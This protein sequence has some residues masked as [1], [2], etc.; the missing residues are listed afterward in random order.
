MAYFKTIVRGTMGASE[1]WSTGISWGIFGLSPDVPD[2]AAVDGILSRLITDPSVLTIPP[3]LLQVMGTGA[4]VVGFR[5]E[6]RAEDESTLAVAEGL[7][8]APSAGTATSSKTPQDAVVISLRTATPGARGRGRLYWPALGAALNGS[9]QL[10]TPTPAA[11][12]AGAATWLNAIG[13]QI[14]DY[15]TDIGA[16]KSAVLVVRSVT[17]HTNADVNQLQVGS[18]LDTQRRRRDN[19]TETYSAV[20]YP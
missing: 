7:W 14:N 16:A 11:I 9:F 2:N 1:V 10:S 19:L 17:S 12:A 15:F 6:Q 5:V 18:V 20:A 4:A 8:P 3:A 13:A